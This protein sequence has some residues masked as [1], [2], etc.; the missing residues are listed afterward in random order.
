MKTLT[1]K[2][3]TEI[4]NI[5]QYKGFSPIT[6]EELFNKVTARFQFRYENE[7]EM[8]TLIFG[9]LYNED[10]DLRMRIFKNSS[11]HNR[12]DQVVIEMHDAEIEEEIESIDPL[13]VNFFC[14]IS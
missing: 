14:K 1:L 13:F 6:V 10:G 12:F 8:A 11:N 5:E 2:I 3:N 9:K 4:A 7:F